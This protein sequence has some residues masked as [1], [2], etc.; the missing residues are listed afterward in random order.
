M[1]TNS[2]SSILSS[3]LSAAICLFSMQQEGCF[4]DGCG[5][6]RRQPRQEGEGE[7]DSWP[8]CLGNVPLQAEGRRVPYG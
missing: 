5:G 1:V 8:M 4:V 3:L 6:R 7:G 2:E